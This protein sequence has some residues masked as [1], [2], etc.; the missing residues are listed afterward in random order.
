M[1]I[2]LMVALFLR[3]P[4]QRAEELKGESS[5]KYSFDAFGR[6]T[7]SCLALGVS[8]RT[9]VSQVTCDCAVIKGFSEQQEALLFVSISYL[10]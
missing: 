3:Q 4:L 8:L 9:A 7:S 10:S 1:A 2:I 6:C 5:Y